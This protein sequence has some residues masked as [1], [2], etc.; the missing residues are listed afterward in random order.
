M[1]CSVT[2]GVD[3]FK[4]CL[5]LVVEIRKGAKETAQEEISLNESYSAFYLALGLR[6][7]RATESGYKTEMPDF[8]ALLRTTCFILS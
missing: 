4:P 2:T 1:S 8:A 6:A 7:V 3:T 5:K